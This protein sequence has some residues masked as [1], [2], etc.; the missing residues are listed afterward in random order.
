M[1]GAHARLNKVNE[2]PICHGET[3]SSEWREEREREKNR[4]FVD[5]LW[6][7]TII[8]MNDGWQIEALFFY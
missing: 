4:K 1:E 7:N 6:I 2:T 8:A 3:I 5:S